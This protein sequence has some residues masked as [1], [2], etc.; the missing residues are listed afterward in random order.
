MNRNQWGG[1][2]VAGGLCAAAIAAV[3]SGRPESAAVNPLEVVNAAAKARKAAPRQAEVEL[4]QVITELDKR[5]DPESQD[6]ATKARME[7]GYLHAEG[8]DA[9]KARAVFLEAEE[10]YKGTGVMSAEYGRL[11]DQAKYQ[12]IA[13]LNAAGKTKEYKDELIEFMRERPLS[14]L[15][16]G[17]H[18]RLVKLDPENRDEYDG[19]LQIAQDKQTEHAKVEMAMCGPRALQ[20]LLAVK[21]AESPGEAELK[22]LCRTDESG[23]TMENM[24]AALESLGFKAEGFEVNSKDY[25]RMPLPAIQLIETHYVVVLKVG[26]KAATIY[27]PMLR[28]ERQLDL[29]GADDAQFKAIV[30]KVNTK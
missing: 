25:A 12:A 24:A 15:V 23:T 13:A 17:V 14:P 26:Q 9:M 16:Q 29:P 30:L 8:G 10:K 4:N 28:G 19:L 11:D 7:L 6:A 3:Y 18:T 22:K 1:I 21:K 2:A 27:D 5:Q 20:K